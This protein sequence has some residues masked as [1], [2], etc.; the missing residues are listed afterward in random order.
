VQLDVDQDCSGECAHTFVDD[1][2]Q[3]LHLQDRS[4]ILCCRQHALA[5]EHAE[6][7]DAVKEFDKV[8]AA[9]DFYQL[10]FAH[11]KHEILIVE[12]F[13]IDV[14]KRLCDVGLLLLSDE[15]EGRISSQLDM[16]LTDQMQFLLGIKAVESAHGR[17][18]ETSIE[19][20]HQLEHVLNDFGAARGRF[21]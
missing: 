4:L 15:P 17:Q 18:D 2:E 8:F 20:P 10:M 12:G 11:Q 9:A 3:L 13:L 6:R 7:S 14:E 16:V 19:A 1:V 5:H 21:V